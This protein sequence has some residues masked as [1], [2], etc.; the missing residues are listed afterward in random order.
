MTISRM[1]GNSFFIKG[2]AVTIVS[3]LFALAAKDANKLYII[4]SY[5]PVISFWIID[6]YY[7]AQERRFRS[8][9]DN[10]RLKD[11]ADIDYSMDTSKFDAARNGWI[12]SMYSRAFLPFYLTLIIAM[13]IVGYTLI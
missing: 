1:A 12:E 2:W 13:L 5:L 4:I 7:L 6:G 10:V 8:L 3:A 11:D 9:Y